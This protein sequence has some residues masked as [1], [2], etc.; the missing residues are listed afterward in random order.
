MEKKIVKAAEY[1][2]SQGIDTV[3]TA[4]ILGTGLGTMVKDIEVDIEI[5]YK[6][7]PHFPESTVEF[8]TGKLIYGKLEGKQVLRRLFATGGYVPHPGDEAVG[9]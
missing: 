4:I 7:I 9:G 2:K 5:P 3:E 6:E 1:I 8:H